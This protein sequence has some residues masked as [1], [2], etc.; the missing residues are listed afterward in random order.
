MLT[1]IRWLIMRVKLRYAS[2]DKQKAGSE[3]DA[4]EREIQ[5]RRMEKAGQHISTPFCHA[6]N[7]P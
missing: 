6:C 3:A 4:R 2:S 5:L 1:V 7:P